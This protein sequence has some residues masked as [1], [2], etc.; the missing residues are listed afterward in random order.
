MDITHVFQ[1]NRC[2]CVFL[3]S[4]YLVIIGLYSLP[5]PTNYTHTPTIHP[6]TPH[7]PQPNTEL[8]AVF[9]Q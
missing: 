6:P 3:I 9:V 8:G 1:N 5:S 2:S 4:M 7:T